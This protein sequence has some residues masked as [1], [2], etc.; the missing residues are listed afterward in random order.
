[1]C[2]PGP[3]TR[4]RSTLPHRS[5]EQREREQREGDACGHGP[6]QVDCVPRTL[7]PRAHSAQAH[8]GAVIDAAFA[9]LVD[10]GYRSTT[11]LGIARR[12]GASKETLYSWFGNKH[13]L[14]AALIRRQAEATAGGIADALEG[15]EAPPATLTDFATQLLTMLVGERSIAINRA[16]MAAPELAEV[17]LA[18]GRFAAG[19]IVEKYLAR[20]DDI[21]VL[22]IADPVAAFRM[23]YGLVV[24]DTQIR[25][26]LGDRQP[27]HAEL[28]AQ[29]AAAVE[30][31]VGLHAP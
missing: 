12:A 7:E 5:D 9:E 28:R 3:S 27:T 1:M 23:L 11:M 10:H 30:T 14:F 16:A 21:G 31:F 6:E 4:P 13:G 15:D 19:P 29:A 2:A 20:L 26:L 22:R 8:R 17:L 18:E 24:Q 25:V